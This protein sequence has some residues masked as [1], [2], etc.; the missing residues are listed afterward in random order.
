VAL[1]EI[2]VPPEARFDEVIVCAE[3]KEIVDMT[4]Y[5]T[6]PVTQPCHAARRSTASA[7]G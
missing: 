7:T 2:I 3:A 4:K 5:F 6:Y 1:N